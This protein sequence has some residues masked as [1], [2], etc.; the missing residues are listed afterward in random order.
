ML[1]SFYDAEFYAD[2][3]IARAGPS[4]GPS[5]S[6]TAVVLEETSSAFLRAAS[7]LLGRY[8]DMRV[9]IAGTNGKEDRYSRAM[10]RLSEE[11]GLA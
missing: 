10:V 8:P 2:P 3:W 11:L 9:R 7:V 4:G 1:A 6:R 5:S